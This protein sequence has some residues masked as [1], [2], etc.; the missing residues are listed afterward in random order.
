MGSDAP[1]SDLKHL[2][3]FKSYATY[4][5]EKTVNLASV[6]YGRGQAAHSRR[7]GARG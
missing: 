6:A 1:A 2:G 3:I 4:S 5:I 7:S